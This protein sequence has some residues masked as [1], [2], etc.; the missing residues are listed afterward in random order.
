MAE[1]GRLKKYL[2]VGVIGNAIGWIIY[3]LIY[4]L[5]PY[6]WNKATTTWL[7]SYLIGVA[8]QHEM[9]R[10][11]TFFDSE[12]KYISSLGKSYLAYS[13][14]LVISTLVNFSLVNSLDVHIQIS[15]F[16]SVVS[17]VVVNYI[18]LKRL[19]FNLT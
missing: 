8:Q 10:R 14:G 4:I 13:L 6:D 3:N 17:S 16:L 9:H 2:S 18:F 19:A 11:W 12:E 7:V 5:N 15:W 1:S